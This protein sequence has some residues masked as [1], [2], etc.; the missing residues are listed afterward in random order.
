MAHIGGIIMGVILALGWHFTQKMH[1]GKIM[2][3]IVL[4]LG[5]VLCFA[6]YQYN[7]YQ[8][9]GLLALW[10]DATNQM[11]TLLIQ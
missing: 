3:M 6:F 2:P 10:Q 9:Q 5:I 8:I 1:A 11:K 4:L 7:Q